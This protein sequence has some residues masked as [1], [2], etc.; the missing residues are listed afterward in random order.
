MRKALAMIAMVCALLMPQRSYAQAQNVTL[1]G[2]I[3]GANGL[4]AAN[5]V[6]NFTPSQVFYIPGLNSSQQVSNIYGNV[7][8]T[9][10]CAVS[11][12]FYTNFTP[13]P[14]ALYQCQFGVWVS[15]TA[16][17]SYGFNVITGGTNTSAAMVVGTGASLSTSGAGTIAATTAA[18][19]AATPGQCTGMTPIATGIQ[20]NGNANCTGVPSAVA[21]QTNSVANISQVLLNLQAGTGLTFTNPSGGIMNAAITA[22]GVT[23]GCYTFGSQFTCLNAQGQLTS[24]GPPYGLSLACTA[25]GSF[26][27]GFASTNPNTC[28][29]SYSN[30]TPASATLIDGVHSAVSL[31]SPYTSGSLTFAYTLNTTFTGNSTA[32]N[33]QMASATAQFAVLNCT[34]AGVGTGGTATGATASGS[35]AGNQCASETATL[36]GATATLVSNGLGNTFAGQT[37][38]FTPNSQYIYLLLTGGCGHTIA[39]NSFTTVFAT[40]ALTYTNILGGSQTGMC[41]Y[42]SPTFYGNGSTTYTVTV[43]TL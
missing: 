37:F 27:I 38:T 34:F 28:T 42:S 31:V 11:G 32:T 20:A 40:Q 36:S 2:T 23:A 33:S 30:G 41:I 43:P 5:S 15:I 18:A 10:P 17:T 14:P 26:E 9:G 39:V 13:H 3:Q 21:L 8:P 12:Q 16:F 6:L 22:T 4:P 19:L 7:P 35:G 24:V 25:A 29:F 1:V